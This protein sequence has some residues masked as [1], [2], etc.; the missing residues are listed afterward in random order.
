RRFTL[1]LVGDSIIDTTRTTD[2]TIQIRKAGKLLKNQK[3]LVEHF[4]EWENLVKNHDPTKKGQKP[5]F[6][7]IQ[8]HL[9]EF[10]GNFIG[11]FGLTHR[12]KMQTRHL[13]IHQFLALLNRPFDPHFLHL[14]IGRAFE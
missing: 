8:V 7:S 12:V 10:L 1:E 5:L 6:K 11:R 2:K 13:S 3:E 9:E 4:L 14:S